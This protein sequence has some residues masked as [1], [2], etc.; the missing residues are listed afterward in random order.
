MTD[1]PFR[2]PSAIAPIV[3]SL[4]ALAGVIAYALLVGV[5]YQADEGTPA[6]LFQLLMV[7]QVPIIAW[8]AVKWLPRAPGRAVIVLAVQALAAMAA[9]GAVVILEA[10]VRP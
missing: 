1:H 9:V 7:A 6:R 2:Q 3:M 4:V 10:S 5:E 8:F